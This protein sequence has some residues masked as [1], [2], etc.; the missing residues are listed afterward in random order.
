MCERPQEMVAKGSTPSVDPEHISEDQAV[1]NFVFLVA[2]RVGAWWLYSRDC[3]MYNFV[4][5]CFSGLRQDC[6]FFGYPFNNQTV[7]ECGLVVRDSEYWS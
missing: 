1:T 3:E 6:G 2:R 4:P 7:G 5:G